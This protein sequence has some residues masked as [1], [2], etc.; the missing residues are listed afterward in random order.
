[1]LEE[2]Q[3][4]VS[5]LLTSHRVWRSFKH[6]S[7]SQEL[8]TQRRPRFFFFDPSWDT[9]TSLCSGSCNTP[10]LTPS[11]AS[12]EISCAGSEGVWLGVLSVVGEDFSC[13]SKFAILSSSSLTA[14]SCVRFSSSRIWTRSLLSIAS[15]SARAFSSRILV[16][17]SSDLRFSSRRLDSSFGP[18]FVC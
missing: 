11:S 9:S 15:F 18:V 3:G 8:R 1:M 13:C 2:I 16:F 14:A 17:S 10:T 6:V 5:A 12:L 7:C 4:R